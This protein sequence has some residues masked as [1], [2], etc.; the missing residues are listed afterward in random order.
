MRRLVALT[1]LLGTCTCTSLGR[2]ALLRGGG[3]AAQLID[4][5]GALNQR[6][7]TELA[8]GSSGAVTLIASY[9]AHARARRLLNDAL[10]TEFDT[11]TSDGGAWLS[12]SSA[13]PSVLALAAEGTAGDA[14][15][16]QPNGTGA[17]TL[18]GF[19]LALADAVLV[20][21]PSTPSVAQLQAG[22]ERLFSQHLALGDGKKTL[23]VHVG[24][25]EEKAVRRAC[26]AAWEKA[27]A[28]AALA[29]ASFEQSFDL[30]SASLLKAPS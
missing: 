18:G 27:T 30:E 16:A 19:S 22:Y 14:L 26:A 28:A 21:T 5:A 9:G 3:R 17:D 10:G 6:A 13:D 11:A 7:A 8:A 25:G 12:S 24:E 2:L 20:H 29:D 15:G 1:A 23:L 4:A